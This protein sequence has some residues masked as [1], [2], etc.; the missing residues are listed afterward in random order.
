MHFW[1]YKIIFNTLYTLMKKKTRPAVDTV[2]PYSDLHK[3]CAQIAKMT[4]H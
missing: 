3:I 1:P 2:K 4:Q